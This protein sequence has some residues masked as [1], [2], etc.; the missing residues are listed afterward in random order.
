MA[1]ISHKAGNS[2]FERTCVSACEPQCESANV[3]PLEITVD[4]ENII[5]MQQ[6]MCHTSYSNRISIKMDLCAIGTACLK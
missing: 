3:E 4:E 5:V 1:E 2:K 6:G